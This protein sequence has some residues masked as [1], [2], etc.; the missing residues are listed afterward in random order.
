MQLSVGENNLHLPA[1]E[2]VEKTNESPGKEKRAL[3]QGEGTE[4]NSGKFVLLPPCKEI[5]KQ[6]CSEIAERLQINR[7]CRL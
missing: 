5:C 7:N 2:N 3:K 6:K 4:R 1:E